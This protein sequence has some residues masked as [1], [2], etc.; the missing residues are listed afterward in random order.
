MDYKFINGMRHLGGPSDVTCVLPH[1]HMD[2]TGTASAHVLSLSEQRQG[3]LAAVTALSKAQ[4][5]R[6]VGGIFIP[7]PY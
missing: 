1:R 4:W 2:L 6:T 7:F 3:A 5:E